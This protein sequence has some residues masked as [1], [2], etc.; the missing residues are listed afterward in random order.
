[1]TQK[2]VIIAEIGE[3]HIGNWDRAKKMVRSAADAGVDIVKFQSYLGSEVDDADEEKEWFTQVALPDEMH[4]ELKVLAESLGVEFLSTPFSPKRA[5][6]LVEQLGLKKIK[7]A[8]SEMLNF[9]ILDFLNG[10]IDTIFLST[11]L[12]SLDEVKIA[13]SHLDQIPEIFILHCTTQYPCLPDQANLS[14]I[15]T[16]I[17]TFPHHGVGFSDHTIGNVAAVTAVGLGAKVVEKH[18]T[19]DK[20][21][22]GTDHVLSN[23][24]QELKALVEQIRQVEKLMGSPIKE[25]IPAELEIRDMV[26]ARFPKA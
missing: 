15:P 16:L 22:E 2:T 10:K 7:I 26:R 25:P 13:V 5:R 17:A 6:F 4:F 3:N 21:L 8:S 20:S 1:M 11:G 23:T 24:P 12:A 19:L 9:G 18:F 14:V